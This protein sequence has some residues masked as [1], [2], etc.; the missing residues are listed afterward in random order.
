[1][2]LDI[3]NIYPTTVRYGVV[4]SLTQQDFLKIQDAVENR[5]RN[6]EQM[7]EIHSDPGYTDEGLFLLCI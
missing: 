3:A 1:M 5:L 7:E 2:K 4:E 6:T